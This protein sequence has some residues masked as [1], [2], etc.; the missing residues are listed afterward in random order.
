MATGGVTGLWHVAAGLVWMARERKVFRANIPNFAFARLGAE[1]FK[2][3]WVRL[4]C[5]ECS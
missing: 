1:R 5:A 4:S 2:A 3:C